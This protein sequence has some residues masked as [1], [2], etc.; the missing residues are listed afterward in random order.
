MTINIKRV[1]AHD[2]LTY[3]SKVKKETYFATIFPLLNA[4]TH[5]QIYMYTY[6]HSPTTNTHRYTFTHLGM[7]LHKQTHTHI[8]IM[9]YD[10]VMN[11]LYVNN[12]SA[13]IDLNVIQ[14]EMDV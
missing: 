8:H 7:H 4:W 11:T 12:P 6:T 13:Q 10:S 3:Y 5:T 9:N 14:T 2:F 1:N